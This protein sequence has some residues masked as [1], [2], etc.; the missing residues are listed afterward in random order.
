VPLGENLYGA[1][2]A[3]AERLLQRHV[4]VSEGFELA[5]ARER[6]GVDGAPT[7]PVTVVGFGPSLIPV[8]P[9]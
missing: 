8:Q 2:E 7:T 3:G 9:I 5:S 6:T 4:E 1:G